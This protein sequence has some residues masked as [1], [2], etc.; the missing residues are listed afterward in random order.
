MFRDEYRE[1]IWRSKINLSFITHSN[2]D[3]FAHKS[4]AIAGC[5]GFL[6]AE[7]SDGHIQRFREDEEA[8][9]FSDIDECVLKIRKYLPDEAARTRIAAA[10][11][12]RAKRDGYYN[13][14][15]MELIVERVRQT[16]GQNRATTGRSA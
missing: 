14:R 1:G 15:Q 16:V 5:G 11:C 10:G 12:A 9:F 3:E 7:R 6:L 2:C 8:V 4:F 13:D